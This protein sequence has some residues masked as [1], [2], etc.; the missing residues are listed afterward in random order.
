MDAHEQVLVVPRGRLLTRG[1]V[2]GLSREGLDGYLAAI[3]AHGTFRD[4]GE[5]EHDPSWKQIIPY[6]VIR[7]GDS[8]FLF[9]R[10]AAG[11][12][13]RLHGRHSIGVGGHI[14]RVDV[15]GASDPVDAGLRRELEE[16]LE[17][18]SAWSARLIGVLNDDLEPVGQVHFGLVFLVETDAPDVRVRESHT[19]RG[20]FVPIASLVEY[21]PRMESWSRLIVEAVDLSAV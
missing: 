7:C 20:E 4:R 9:Q 2:H 14:N 19:L 15:E 18:T 16:E 6:L 12:E 5:V 17:V 13:A 11:G 10:T 1:P 21:A 8:V 3:A